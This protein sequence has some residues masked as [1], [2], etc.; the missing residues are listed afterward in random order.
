MILAMMD[1]F[2]NT[3]LD[4]GFLSCLSDASKSP[5]PETV[6]KI[7]LALVHYSDK[8]TLHDIEALFNYVGRSIK[9]I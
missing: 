7:A 8:I 2:S 6:M 3:G 1:A 4:Q 9:A 5:G